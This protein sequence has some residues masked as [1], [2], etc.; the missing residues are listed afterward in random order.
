[1]TK[2]RQFSRFAAAGLRAIGF[3]LLGACAA[4]AGWL[5]RAVAQA[6]GHGTTSMELACAAALVAC[7]MLGLAL[8]VE[9]P[10]LFRHLPVPNRHFIL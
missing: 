10:G 9:G 6:P 3:A 8:T 4:L 2:Q 7:L 5:H 1:V